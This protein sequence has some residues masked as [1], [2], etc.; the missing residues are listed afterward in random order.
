MNVTLTNEQKVKVTLAPTTAS[1]KPAKI[2]GIPSWTVESGDATVDVAEDGLSAYI[3][4]GEAEGAS[5]V[6]LVADADLGEGVRNIEEVIDVTVT[7]AEASA[8]GLTVGT[9]EPK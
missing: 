1:G 7:G 5:T 2:D 6:R 4:S 9:A 3:I 8:L